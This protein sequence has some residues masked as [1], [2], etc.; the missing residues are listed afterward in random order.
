MKK[1]KIAILFGGRS[2]EYGVSL[3]S[4][5]AVLQQIDHRRFEPV[6]IGITQEGHWFLFT[7]DIADLPDDKWLRPECTVPAVISPD[8]GTKGL[9]VLRPEGVETVELDAAFPVLHGKFGEDGTVQG[10]LEM[11]G[12]PIVG[13]KTLASALCMDKER[14]N[15]LTEDVGVKV[16]TTVVIHAGADSAAVANR[17]AAIGYPVFVKPV[18]AGSSFGVTEVTVAEDLAD[19]L[20]VA[21]EYDNRVMIQ[22]KI[23]GREIGCAV[24]GQGEDIFIGTLDEVQLSGGFF[25]F[26]EKY[27]HKSSDILLPARVSA[28]KTAEIKESAKKI[29]RALDCSGMARVDVFLTDN[30]EIVF[31]EVNTIPGFTAMSRYPAMMAEAGLPFQELITQLIEA[32]LHEGPAE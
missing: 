8:R 22:E 6:L 9:L 15:R 27:T 7:G 32:A 24:M 26:T 14:A 30:G 10:L 29:Y 31:N 17:V 16:P 3:K 19:A 1:Q 4:A 5:Y 2:S 28:E 20:N 21:F 23:V 18:K 25:D 12:I 11:A 13:C